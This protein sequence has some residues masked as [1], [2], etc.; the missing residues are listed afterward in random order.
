MRVNHERL[1]YLQQ[2]IIFLEE[3]EQQ[4]KYFTGLSTGP[5]SVSLP[6]LDKYP[7]FVL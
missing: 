5:F 1:A 4:K 6:P 2:L 7:R 3:K